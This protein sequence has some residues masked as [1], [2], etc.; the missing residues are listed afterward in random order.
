MVLEW[1]IPK[2]GTFEVWIWE[3]FVREFHSRL[4]THGSLEKANLWL[5]EST[6][7]QQQGIQKSQTV[8]NNDKDETEL[9]TGLNLLATQVISTASAHLSP[10][11]HPESAKDASDKTD[12]CRLGK[13]D[14]VILYEARVRV[15][16]CE[17]LPAQNATSRITWH[18]PFTAGEIREILNDLP[19][20][21]TNPRGFA[22]KMGVNQLSYGMS[23]ADCARILRAAVDKDVAN[24]IIYR[25]AITTHEQLTM[26]GKEFCKQLTDKMPTMYSVV[27]PFQFMTAIQGPDEDASVYWRRDRLMVARPE[28]HSMSFH[29][30]MATIQAIELD[31]HAR[32]EA[33]SAKIMAALELIAQDPHPYPRK[34]KLPKRTNITCFNCDQKGHLARHCPENEDKK[35]Q[36]SPSPYKV[37]PDRPHAHN[38]N[39]GKSYRSTEGP[40]GTY[41]FI[42]DPETVKTIGAATQSHSFAH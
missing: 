32:K 38:P 11:P 40:P 16:E 15:Q 21:R 7:L 8:S 34:K 35:E 10:S 22:K 41:H 27:S 25:C 4:Q 30:L 37:V 19:D 20:H 39:P 23:G 36:N 5:Q 33:K 3:K 13:S 12:Y 17:G 24:D 28:A 31:L 29:S 6:K 18:V 26:G 42:L 1:S 2:E 14:L 9:Q